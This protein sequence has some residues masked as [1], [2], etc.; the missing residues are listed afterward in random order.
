MDDKS[1]LWIYFDDE[2]NDFCSDPW[3]TILDFKFVIPPFVGM[4]IMIEACQ[5]EVTRVCQFG[6]DSQASIGVDCVFRDYDVK[7]LVNY[8]I[9]LNSKNIDVCHELANGEDIQD[10]REKY[11]R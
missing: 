10:I 3:I 7:V 5:G 9:G 4:D 11:R 6:I 2:E 1:E 8:L